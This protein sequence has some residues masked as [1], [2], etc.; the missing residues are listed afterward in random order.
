MIVMY[1]AVVYKNLMCFLIYVSGFS[2]ICL[3]GGTLL[4]KHLAQALPT[5]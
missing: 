5:I 3:P 1:T 4:M 2:L